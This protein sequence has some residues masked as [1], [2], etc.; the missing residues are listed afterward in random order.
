M[1]TRMQLDRELEQLEQMLP[2][3]IEKLRHPSEFWPQFDALAQAIVDDAPPQDVQYVQ[4][5]LA[6]M[7]QQHGLHRGHGPGGYD[8]R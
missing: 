3:W 8:D 4:H 5:R 7:Q 1:S 6:L 2:I